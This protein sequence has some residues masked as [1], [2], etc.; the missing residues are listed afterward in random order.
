MGKID[1]LWVELGV[2]GVGQATLGD[3]VKGLGDVK[4]ASL[5]AGGALAAVFSLIAE[6]TSA[7]I[8]FRTFANATGLSTDEL[9]RWQNA[10]VLA[11]DSTEAMSAA[12]TT[13]QQRLQAIKM[14]KYD[15]AFFKLGVVP[16]RT[17][18]TFAVLRRIMS[19]RG[20]MPAA[21]YSAFVTELGLGGIQNTLALGQSG[22]SQA[23][24]I[25][26]MS[27]EQIDKNIKFM[28]EFKYLWL[29]AR[30][31]A[32]DI[33]TE[34]IGPMSKI[35]D[36]Y[37]KIFEFV[38]D[39]RKSPEGTIT[40]N[41]AGTWRHL[42]GS[43]GNPAA[44]L[45]DLRTGGLT[46]DALGDAKRIGMVQ[47]TLTGDRADKDLADEVAAKVAKIIEMASDQI[48]TDSPDNFV[49]PGVTK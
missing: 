13:L 1:S 46:G 4:M 7:S 12:V 26:G 18:D 5:A 11:N 47:V 19:R 34:L 24:G 8:S 28:R 41:A 44:M 39:A 33:G 10:A 35:I 17:E 25:Q 16:G 31:L 9:Q 36:G 2:K 22:L 14:G 30:D 48:P 6:S 43:F 38:Q 27:Q 21:D 45:R 37:T 42:F 3:F 23:G 40:D 20:T 29:Q 49:I 32:R 15:P